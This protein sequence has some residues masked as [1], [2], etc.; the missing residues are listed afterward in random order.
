MQKLM[1]GFLI[2]LAALFSANSVNA[3][4]DLEVNTPAIAALKNSMQARHTQLAPHYGSGAIGLTSDGLIAVRDTTAVPLRD[5]QGINALVAAEN[6][7]RNALYKEIAAGNGHP[8]WRGDIQ[9][10]FAGRWIDKAQGG[11]WYQK[12]GSWVKK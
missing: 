7:D 4:A 5:R 8:E 6:A 10:T 1:M 2:I 11:W 12:E 3:A 9:S